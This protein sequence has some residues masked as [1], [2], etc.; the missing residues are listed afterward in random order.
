[1]LAHDFSA[2]DSA[3]IPAGFSRH[4]P[5]V[6]CH[7]SVIC[8]AWVRRLGRMLWAAESSVRM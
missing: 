3:R 8:A 1:M 4:C 7:Q 2:I 6:T 5:I